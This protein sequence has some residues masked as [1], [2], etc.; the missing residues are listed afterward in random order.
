MK[1]FLFFISFGFTAAWNDFIF[2]DNKVP[3]LSTISRLNKLKFLEFSF[4]KN[5]NL[6]K[7]ICKILI[8]KIKINERNKKNNK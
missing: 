2:L 4:E 8:L 1:F 6:F 3:F 7:E 5:S